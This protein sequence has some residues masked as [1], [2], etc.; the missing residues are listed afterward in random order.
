MNMTLRLPKS[1]VFSLLTGC[2]MGWAQL[3]SGVPTSSRGPA[4]HPS[5]TVEGQSYTPLSILNR[6]MGTPEDQTTAFPPHRIIGNIY[7]VGT[8]TLS[9]FLVVTPEGNILIDSTYERNTPVI[10]K[11]VEQLGFK[12]SDIKIL[13]GNHAHGDHME[14]DAL[15]KQLTG[16]QVV[17]MAED[18][19]ALQAL[20]PGGKEHP[21][22]RVIH[23]NDTVTLGGTV[24]VAHLTPGHT[25][26]C[27]TWTTTVQDSGKPYHVVF[28]CS[29]RAPNVITPAIAEEFTR[30]FQ[31]VRTLPCDV[32]LGDHTSEYGMQEKYA[33]MKPGA[34]NPYIDKASCRREIDIEEAMFHAIMAEQ[35]KSA[36]P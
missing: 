29:L 2:G 12:F 30:S 19:P 28:G 26:G 14:G 1:V 23:D 27:T 32:Q 8:K 21:I 35:Q 33:R 13:L 4:D 34:P 11:S 18:V 24:L 25:H 5:V 9:S 10:L 7:Y 17:V 6:N 22:D 36:Q 20:K 16:A 3:Q 31:V 15:V